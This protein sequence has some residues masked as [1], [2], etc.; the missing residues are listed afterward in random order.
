M[1]KLPVAGPVL[2][3]A[4]G[5]AGDAQRNRKYHGGPDRAV[6]LFSIELYDYLR[7]KGIDLAPGSVGENFTT[8]D[9]DLQRLAKGDRLRVGHCTI[10]ITDVRV[11]CH[12]LKIWDPD[13]P[14]LIVGHSGW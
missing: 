11:P 9:L 6:C 13:L 8:A 1:P 4:S 2:V 3:T 14:E 7:D 5:L 12:Q 10:Q